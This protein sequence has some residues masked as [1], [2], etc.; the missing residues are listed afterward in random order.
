MPFFGERRGWGHILR[1]RERKQKSTACGRRRVDW[2]YSFYPSII[3]SPPCWLFEAS[4]LLLLSENFAE[5]VI[6]PS[7]IILTMLYT[8]TLLFSDT[9]LQLFHYPISTVEASVYDKFCKKLVAKVS[10]FT[11]RTIQMTS[12]LTCSL[13]IELLFSFFFE[14]GESLRP[15]YAPWACH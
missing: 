6:C 15:S 2:Y 11:V 3:S 1:E 10:N 9:Y 8:R 4:V 13:L 5:G 14:G 7:F 12:P